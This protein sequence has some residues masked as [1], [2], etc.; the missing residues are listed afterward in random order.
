MRGRRVTGRERKTDCHVPI[1]YLVDMEFWAT[2][3]VPPPSELQRVAV[4]EER[5][6]LWIPLALPPDSGI[7]KR[8]ILHVLPMISV[9]GCQ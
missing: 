5:F 7:G 4:L 8:V 3:N 2:H 1:S 6:E 9:N